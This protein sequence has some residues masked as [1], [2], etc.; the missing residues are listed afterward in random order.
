MLYL[1]VPRDTYHRL[2]NCYHATINK[3][4]VLVRPTTKAASFFIHLLFDP[5]P[6]EQAKNFMNDGVNN[7]WVAERY[8]ERQDK[9]TGEYLPDAKWII[10]KILPDG[11][12]TVSSL[13]Y[14]K[15]DKK[16]K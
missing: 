2:E 6:G 10:V 14:Q 1:Y 15:R 13:N 4:G 8:T 3:D 5:R 9:I 12:P 7:H 11:W 16:K